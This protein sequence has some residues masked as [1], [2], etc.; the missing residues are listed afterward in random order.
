MSNPCALRRVSYLLCDVA[1]ANEW[2]LPQ[3]DT[4]PTLET[5]LRKPYGFL[6]AYTGYFLHVGTTENE[7]NE[8]GGDA[9]TLSPPERRI[10]RLRHEESKWDPEYYMY[11]APFPPNVKPKRIDTKRTIGRPHGH[12]HRQPCLVLIRADFSDNEQIEELI[13]WTHP[14]L[15]SPSTP[16]LVFT[17]AENA[18]M[19]RL[20]RKECRHTHA[21]H[22][23]TLLHHVSFF[24]IGKMPTLGVS[25]DRLID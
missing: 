22:H 18:T 24:F 14:H 2:T 5:S 16:V 21:S 19:L 4:L 20:P 11:V 23:L 6:N 12:R 10:R 15:D 17:E 7:I 9:E 13:A 3:S 1:A 25:D 8:L